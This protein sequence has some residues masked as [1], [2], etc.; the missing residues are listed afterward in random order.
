MQ[1]RESRSQSPQF[2]EQ[3]PN[4]CRV[5]IVVIWRM[6]FCLC[7]SSGSRH[8]FLMR[9]LQNIKLAH[10]QAKFLFSLVSTGCCAEYLLRT[11]HFLSFRIGKVGSQNPPQGFSRSV[12]EESCQK[13]GAGS[14]ER[15]MG[16]L[17][18]GRERIAFSCLA[19]GRGAGAEERLKPLVQCGAPGPGRWRLQRR[20]R[21]KHHL[22]PHKEQTL[23]ISPTF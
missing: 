20:E 4:L 12:G 1:W 11:W 6:V 18:R 7:H 13:A 17:P 16:W 8:V 14:L 2:P 5:R 3:L 21:L 23:L 10:F 22:H 19:S 9:Q 15:R